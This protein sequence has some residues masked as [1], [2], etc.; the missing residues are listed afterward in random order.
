MKNV[1]FKSIILIQ[2]YSTI[3]CNPF[4]PIF[5]CCEAEVLALVAERCHDCCTLLTI[6]K[7]RLIEAKVVAN[8][9]NWSPN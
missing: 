6:D 1:T 3:L 5:G 7:Q 8:S 2:E 9:E 4:S